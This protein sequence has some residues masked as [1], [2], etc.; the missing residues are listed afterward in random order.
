[1][2]FVQNPI[3]TY[4]EA[5]MATMLPAA[6]GLN[7]FYNSDHGNKLYSVD[8]AGTFNFASDNSDDNDCCTCELTERWLC[9]LNDALNDGLIT[10]GQYQAAIAL[11]FTVTSTSDGNGG[12]YIKTSTAVVRPITVIVSPSTGSVASGTQLQ[13]GSSVTPAGAYPNVFWLSSNTDKATVDQTGYVTT[14]DTGNV[15]ITAYSLLDSSISGECVV[16]IT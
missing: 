11:G 14:L 16:T 2:A 5:Q 1:M 9:G 13:L 7:F 4:S 8:S 6:G 12:C 15:T 3:P 10:P